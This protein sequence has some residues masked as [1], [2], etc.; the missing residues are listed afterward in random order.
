MQVLAELSDTL[1]KYLCQQ[2]HRVLKPT[3]ILYI[4]DHKD[5]WKP[6]H[7]L[8]VDRYFE[9]NGFVKEFE[10]HVEDGVDFKGIPRIFRKLNPSVLEQRKRGTHN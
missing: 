8:D 9:E 6:V 3:G 7:Q 2:F 4:R 10:L 5:L 1:V